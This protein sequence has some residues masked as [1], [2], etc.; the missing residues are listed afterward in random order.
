MPP[1]KKMD[2]G[3]SGYSASQPNNPDVLWFWERTTRKIN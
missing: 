2:L 3:S 1:V